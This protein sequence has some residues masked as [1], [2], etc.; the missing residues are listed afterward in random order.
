LVTNICVCV[1]FELFY[2]TYASRFFLQ[3]VRIAGN[4]EH[5]NGVKTLRTQY[6]SDPRHFGT[7]WL[8]PKCL[9]SLAPVP[10]CLTDTLAQVPNC[11]DLHQTFFCYSSP[12][13]RKIYY[14]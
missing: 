14:I 4:E 11:L 3:R 5:C 7:I 1:L 2:F 9:D 10:K 13:R 6:T 8:V 12:Y